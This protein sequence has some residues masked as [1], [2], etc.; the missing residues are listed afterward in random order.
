MP[1]LKVGYSLFLYR[2]TTGPAV[3][4]P[5]IFR[6]GSQPKDDGF[7]KGEKCQVR[8]EQSHCKQ[9]EWEV[10]KERGLGQTREKGKRERA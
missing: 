4:G 2:K 9:V 10:S 3:E 1:H 7:L 8:K 5:N 6:L